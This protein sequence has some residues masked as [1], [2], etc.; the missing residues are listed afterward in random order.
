MKWWKMERT[1]I[2]RGLR[3]VAMVPCKRMLTYVLK[4]YLYIGQQIKLP[5]L[6]VISKCLIKMVNAFKFKTNFI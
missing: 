4:S 6:K 2:S 1:Y 3:I 5:L